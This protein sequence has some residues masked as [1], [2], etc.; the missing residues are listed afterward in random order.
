M[1]RSCFIL[2]LIL[3]ICVV[4]TGTNPQRFHLFPAVGA[5]ITRFANNTIDVLQGVSGVVQGG[6]YMISSTINRIVNSAGTA[7]EKIT[8]LLEEF[9]R[10]MQKGIP[11]LGIPILEPLLIEKIEINVGSKNVGIVKGY[12]ENVEIR[13]LSE[14][15]VDFANWDFKHHLTLN[16]SFPQIDVKGFYFI[17]ARISKMVKIYGKGSFWLKL[18]GLSLG[19]VS[20]M[21]YDLIHDPPFYVK[22]MSIGAKLKKLNNNFSN[23][24]DNEKLGYLI[25]EVISNVTPSA[26]DILWPD[27]EPGITRQIVDIINNKLKIFPLSN[28]IGRVLNIFNLNQGKINIHT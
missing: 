16:F 21:K 20:T 24:M 15:T 9:R 3:W 6:I 19:T 28:I 4:N 27:L 1:A 17:D 25:N 2:F 13:R 22:T 10:Y 23:L 11:E 26:L 8:R 12:M 7:R 14:F 5:A 18:F